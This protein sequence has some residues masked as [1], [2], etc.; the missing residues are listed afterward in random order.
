MTEYY[1]SKAPLLNFTPDMLI[2]FFVGLG[3]LFALALIVI[4]VVDYIKAKN[5]SC[6]MLL[7][8]ILIFT[9]QFINLFR[10][11]EYMP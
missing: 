6:F 5:K 9:C 1:A 10:T 4:L 8:G 2:N 7:F 11:M 3:I